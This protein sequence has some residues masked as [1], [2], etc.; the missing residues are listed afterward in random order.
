[1]RKDSSFTGV[2]LEQKTGLGDRRNSNMALKKTFK[3]LVADAKARITEIQPDELSR[4]MQARGAPVVIDVR[5]AEDYARAHIAGALGLSRG[6]LE[7][8]IDERVPDTEAEI[9]LYCG[10]GSRSALAADTLQTMG[11][12]NVKSLAGGFRG[13]AADPGRR[14][15]KG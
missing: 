5:E 9:V 4:R 14:I 13:W 6:V 11:Y 2:R 7:L 10:G 15:E 8:H 3:D 12:T 1:M